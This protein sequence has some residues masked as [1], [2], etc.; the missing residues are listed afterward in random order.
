M[1]FTI[2]AGP[3]QSS[4]PQVR[5]PRD[6]Y[7]ILFSQIQ[8]SP[9]LEGQ[10]SEFISPRNRVAQLYPRHGVPLSSPP[11][12]LKTTVEVFDPTSIRLLIHKAQQNPYVASAGTA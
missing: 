4:L 3:G 9:N 1:S 12:T 2:A 7:H 6:S 8:D 5:I 11:T 10:V